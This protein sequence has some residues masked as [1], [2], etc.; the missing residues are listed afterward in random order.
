MPDQQPRRRVLTYANVAATLALVF[1][2]TGG[3]LAAKH[4]LIN[5]TGQI[6]PKV[7]RKL[8]GA[9]G[10]PGAP[11]KNGEAGKNGETGKEG[12]QG[13]GAHS[14]S[15]TV[16]AESGES[17]ITTTNNGLSVIGFCAPFWGRILLVT[18]SG[19]ENMQAFGYTINEKATSLERV[20]RNNYGTLVDATSVGTPQDGDVEVTARNSA[21]P[22]F[23]HFSLHVTIPAAKQPCTY[24]GMITPAG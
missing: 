4:Y 21:Y 14:F 1:S 18:S 13:P 12:P 11:G 10:A 16:P 24:Q 22:N 19:S 23:E 3:A 7:L 6:N 8:R 17:T 15:V 9:T 5:S 2:M 20:D